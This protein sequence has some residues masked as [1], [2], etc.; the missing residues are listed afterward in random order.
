M[1]TT[2]PPE[3][4][5][6]LFQLDGSP[7]MLPPSFTIITAVLPI[8]FVT[9]PDE[10]ARHNA[11]LAQRLRAEGF[12]PLPVIG[13][14]PRADGSVHEEASWLVACPKVRA[15]ALGREYRQEAVWWVEGDALGAVP[16]LGLYPETP[17]TPGLRARLCHK[18]P[19][20]GYRKA[21]GGV[22]VHPDGQRV[23]LRRPTPNPGF[24]DLEWTFAK[25][26]LDG[27]SVEVAALREVRE[28]LGVA[29]EIRC[30]IPGW[31]LGRTTANRYFVM[32]WQADVQQPDFETADVR[33]AT[34]TEAPALMRL[35]RNEDALERDV[36]ILKAAQWRLGALDR[37]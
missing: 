15:V 28:E 10:D 18:Q 20:T 5:N 26:R 19:P 4:A 25:G 1:T 27:E 14:A 3:Y 24:D 7:L 9:S 31:F 16:C 21:A 34:W 13:W 30:P 32:R 11:E 17:V 37:G 12:H 2:M 35:G 23:L 33:W 29:A 22:V 8:G 6:T 36:R